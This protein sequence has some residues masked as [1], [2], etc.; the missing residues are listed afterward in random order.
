[1]WVSKSKRKK[2]KNMDENG[3]ERGGEKKTGR[4]RGDERKTGVIICELY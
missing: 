3:C 1:M 2:D 4:G